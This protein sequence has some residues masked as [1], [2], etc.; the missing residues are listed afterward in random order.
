MELSTHGRIN[1]RTSDSARPR[2]RGG[3]R[4]KRPHY[5]HLVGKD[6]CTVVVVQAQRTARPTPDMAQLRGSLF[7]DQR[8]IA[9]ALNKRRRR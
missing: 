4:L 7:G 1:L 3:F 5:T 6:W 2:C 8:E 9:V